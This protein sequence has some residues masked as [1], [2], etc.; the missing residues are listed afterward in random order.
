MVNTQPLKHS[1]SRR[2]YGD[3]FFVVIS[4]LTLT[5]PIL[6]LPQ[7]LDNAFNTPKTTLMLMGVCVMTGIYCFQYFQGRE[8]LVLKSRMPTVALFLICL[9]VFSFFYTENPYYTIIAAMMNIT[10]L[11]LFYFVSL[12]MEGNKP[13]FLILF[14][15]F[16]GLL[17]SVECYLQFL[18]IFIIFKWAYKGIMIMGTIGNS[19]YLGAYLIFP[20]YAAAGLIF[21]THGKKRFVISVLFLFILGAFLFTR[22]RAGWFGFFVSF[23]F[24]LFFMKRIFGIRVLNYLRQNLQGVATGIMLVISL[25]VT[26]WYISPDQFHTM[27]DY[28][29]LTNPMTLHL[30]VKKYFP[31]SFWLFKQSPLFGTGLWSYRKLVFQAQAEIHQKDDT[32]FVNYPEPKPESP[33]NEYLEVLNDGGIVAACALLIFLAILM[34]HGW[35]LIHEKG[36]DR[37]DRIIAATALSSI[38][39]IMLAAIL[40][41]AFRINSTLFMTAL[42][43]GVLEGL[44]GKNC[45][46]VSRVKRDRSPGSFILIALVFL[47]LTGWVWFTGIKVFMGEVEHFKYK[48]SLVNN[49]FQDALKY[50]LRA[51]QY[52]PH[53][54][55]YHF[56]TG[57]LYMNA[58]QDFGKAN[59]HIERA[60]I[61]YNGDLTMWSLYFI[62]GL[63]KMQMGSPLEAQSALE[64]AIYFN[65]NFDEARQKLEEVRKIIKE[66][67]K[68]LIQFR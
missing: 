23:P 44:Y 61:D 10:C 64:K 52:N 12:H 54:S 34:K 3:P 33:H 26:L 25:L 30:R 46:L 63:L 5:V 22:A 43:M 19:N 29:N 51:I 40:F 6:V 68:V 60:L 55:V 2:S 21:L 9:N 39:A 48:K 53:N 17:V 31:S 8:F 16:S 38:L 27:M 1:Q 66:H 47:V 20:L 49:Q 11:L 62:K 58:F 24:F 36:I 15:A 28:R 42:M 18:G 45:G 65:P 67:D 50:I 35:R 57:Q 7:I 13:L 14:T 41:F 59:D 56:Y 4:I 32:F 37:R